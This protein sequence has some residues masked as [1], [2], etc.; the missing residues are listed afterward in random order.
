M[1]IPKNIEMKKTKLSPGDR[2]VKHFKD[3]QNYLKLKKRAIIVVI[4]M[5][6]S[7]GFMREKKENCYKYDEVAKESEKCHK[8]GL[9]TFQV[10]L[11]MDNKEIDVD[12]VFKL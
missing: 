5:Y 9:E 3:L 11:K 12:K 2:L 10:N 8:L 4:C 6:D 1:E 7:D